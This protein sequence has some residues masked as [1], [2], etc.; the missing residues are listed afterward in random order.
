MER[1]LAALLGIAVGCGAV[2]CTFDVDGRAP[3][4]C[5]EIK[6]RDQDAMSGIRTLVLES[7]ARPMNVYCEMDVGG[8]GWTLWNSPEMGLYYGNEG[9]PRCGSLQQTDCFAGTFAQRGERVGIYLVSADGSVSALGSDLRPAPV[10]TVEET[11]GPCSTS[12]SCDSGST[13]C[14]FSLLKDGP[15]CCTEPSQHNVCLVP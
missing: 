12:A 15:G 13:Y 9:M 10:M 14:L 6:A 3:R 11:H 7:R 2:G 8:G 1:W 5:A 4:N